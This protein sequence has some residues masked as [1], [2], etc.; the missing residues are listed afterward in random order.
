MYLFR[1]LVKTNFMIFNDYFYWEI[2][3]VTAK[4]FCILCKLLIFS[5]VQKKTLLRIGKAIP[6]CTM[7]RHNRN[8]A[9]KSNV[10][11]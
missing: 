9:Y 3:N 8:L 5:L 7:M 2:F 10:L 6:K 4:L 11:K 1:R